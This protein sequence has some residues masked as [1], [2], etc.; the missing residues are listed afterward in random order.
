MWLE[1]M[2]LWLLD[3]IHMV[4]R[5]YG[6]GIMILVLI[7]RTLLHPLTKF[8][9][10]SMFRMQEGMARMQPKQEAIKQKYAND[11]V[12]QNQEIMKLFAE[13]GV[14]PA[15][16]FVSFLPMFVQMPI[17]VALWTALNTDIHLRHAPFDGWWIVDLSAP[18]SLLTFNPPVTVPILGYLPLIGS[19]FSGVTSLNV[20]PILMGLSMWLQQKYMP[21]PQMKPKL[22][23]SKAR[24]GTSPEDQMRQ[25][26]L[27]AYMM[28][29]LFPLMFYKMPAGLNLYWMATNV[30]GIC[31]SLIIRKQLERDRQKRDQGGPQPPRR[32]GL[33]S[34]FFKRIAEQAEQLQKKADE[35]SK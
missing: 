32:P 26:T 19:V 33:V 7:V 30:F 25:Q 9:Q 28:A 22:D 29:V 14:N 13:E 15:G 34:R 27:M 5:N 35:L 12:K 17:L 10:K 16:S 23:A 31:E 1:E 2:M 24:G 8:Q 11:K 20:L 18:D 6:V 4:V 3:K 21:K